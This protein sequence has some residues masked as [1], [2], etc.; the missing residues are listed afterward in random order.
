[1]F[2]VTVCIS[3]GLYLDSSYVEIFG[4]VMG[5][6][7]V[8]LCARQKVISFLFGLIAIATFAY[9]YFET[10]LYAMVVIAIVQIGFN[11]YG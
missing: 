3:S 9:I 10:G 7:N 4:L 1:M 6:I 8:W 2:A 5:V 11:V